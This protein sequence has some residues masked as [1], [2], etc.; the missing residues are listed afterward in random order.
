VNGNE[1]PDYVPLFLEFLAQLLADDAQKLLGDAI[2]VLAMLGDK[3]KASDSPYH[4]IFGVT[5][6]RCLTEPLP[7]TEPP[8]R[9]MDE[10]LEVFGPGADGVEPL[11]KPFTEQAI[12]FY[13][14]KTHAAGDIKP[15]ANL[16]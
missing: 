16:G 15:S 12:Q 6:A 8:I 1:L 14:K 2:H 4:C 3:L 5:R 7:F 11:L 13:P 9:D 10:A